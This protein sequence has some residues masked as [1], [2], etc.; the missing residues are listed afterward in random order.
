MPRPNLA[1]TNYKNSHTTTS[2]S[3][4]LIKNFVCEEGRWV[5]CTTCQKQSSHSISSTTNST[6]STAAISHRQ[7][8][9]P[10]DSRTPW[11]ANQSNSQHTYHP[12]KLSTS[13]FHL[14]VNLCR[15]VSLS[16]PLYKTAWRW[17]DGF[18]GFGEAMELCG[19]CGSRALQS[20]VLWLKEGDFGVNCHPSRGCGGG[21]GVTFQSPKSNTLLF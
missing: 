15:F 12:Q 18:Q 6:P 3:G 17:H 7:K 19:F 10:D 9:S 2:T 13:K 1:H 20:A 16:L 14:L 8:A 11:L 21:W 5:R 4:R